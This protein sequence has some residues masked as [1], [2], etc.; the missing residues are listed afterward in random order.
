MNIQI[1][2]IKQLVKANNNV[3]TKTLHCWTFVGRVDQYLMERT[4]NAWCRHDP[5]LKRQKAPHVIITDEWLV[6]I[7][8][9]L[10]KTYQKT[11]LC[12]DL[13]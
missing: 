13:S 1:S 11:L 8:I 4:I 2:S 3:N 7:E 10:E 5:T 9:N 12:M 6:S